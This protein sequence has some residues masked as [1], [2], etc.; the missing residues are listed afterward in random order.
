M[1]QECFYLFP[2]L[3]GGQLQEL[4]IVINCLIVMWVFVWY[5]AAFIF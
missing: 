5:P 4:N 3:F 2:A 1:G